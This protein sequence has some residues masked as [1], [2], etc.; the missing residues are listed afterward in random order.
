MTTPNAPTREEVERLVTR[1]SEFVAYYDPKHETGRG[2]V[3]SCGQALRALLDENER[4]NEK[5]R[6]WADALNRYEDIG[7]Q[8]YDLLAEKPVA[9][10]DL[11]GFEMAASGLLNHLH[12]PKMDGPR[13]IVERMLLLLADGARRAIN[14]GRDT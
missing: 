10:E 9:R 11:R 7:D 4:L 3:D 5:N 2:L 14:G 6:S 12:G 8:L 13:N 1:C